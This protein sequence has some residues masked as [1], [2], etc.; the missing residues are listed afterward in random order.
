MPT[1]DPRTL[2]SRLLSQRANLLR[3]AGFH[4]ASIEPDFVV[5]LGGKVLRMWGYPPWQLR[6][7]EVY[8]L[9]R[10]LVGMW[11]EFRG[12]QKFVRRW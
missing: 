9:P 1:G 11:D 6:A 10:G 12:M 7:A 4:A 3:G 2:T 8:W 5:V